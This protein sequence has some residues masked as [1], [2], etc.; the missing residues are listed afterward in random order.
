MSEERLTVT[1]GILNAS[2]QECRELVPFFV[3]QVLLAPEAN[4]YR[5]LGVDR[6]AEPGLIRRHYHYLIRLFHPDRETHSDGW[7]TEYAG[8]I[9]EAYAQLK[10]PE[11]RRAYDL[12]LDQEI[13][14]KSPSGANDFQGV[15]PRPLDSRR[16]AV[17]ISRPSPLVL[18]LGIVTGV[19]CLLLM[20]AAGQNSRLRVT[21]ASDTE[22]RQEAVGARQ[23]PELRY[24]GAARFTETQETRP[25]VNALIKSDTYDE[26]AKPTVEDMVQARLAAA[27]KDVLGHRSARKPASLKRFHAL[28]SDSTPVLNTEPVENLKRSAP[29]DN[30]VS[31]DQD[32]MSGSQT[33]EHLNSIDQRDSFEDFSE[34]DKGITT[35]GMVESLMEDFRLHYENGNAERFAKLF[36]AD[37]VTTDA[38]GREMIRSLYEY[39]FARPESR[40]I[41]LYDYEWTETSSVFIGKGKAR[42][43]TIPFDDSEPQSGILTM[44]FRIESLSEG[45]LITRLDYHW[46]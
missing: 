25:A 35:L 30:V 43:T 28:K 37:S 31:M 19:C 12:S 45:V 23:A 15:V 9:N 13:E 36:S 10:N 41:T 4:L 20:L 17:K 26:S 32:A 5:C 39:F 7:Y 29:R 27:T 42:I 6:H 21:A 3:K 2:T 1:A 16:V 38:S 22:S 18:S 33:S 8:R 40:E 11:K 46:D 14:K 34:S 24:E 44:I